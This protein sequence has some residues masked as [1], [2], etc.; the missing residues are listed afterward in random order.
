MHPDLCLDVQ[1]PSRQRPGLSLVGGLKISVSLSDLIDVPTLLLIRAGIELVGPLQRVPNGYAWQ[2][3]RGPNG[4][5]Y[6]V[7]YDP[8][9]S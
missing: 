8:E 6:E 3:F 5:M 2:H 1:L 4:T 9:R 7:T